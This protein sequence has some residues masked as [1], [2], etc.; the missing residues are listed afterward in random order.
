MKISD[1]AN[2]D[3]G[4]QTIERYCNLGDGGITSNTVLF[5]QVIGLVNQGVKN[6]F[7][8]LLTVD[9]QWKIDDSAYTDFPT[10]QIDLVSGTRDYLLP[11]A[12]VGGDFSTLYKINFVRV[13]NASGQKMDLLPL[14]PKDDINNEYYSAGT[15]TGTP[16]HYKLSGKSIILWPTPVTGSVTLT[17]GLEVDFQRSPDPFTTADTS[18]QFGFVDAFHDIPCLYASYHLLLPTNPS[19]A[20]TYFNLYTQRMEQL[21]DFYDDMDDAPRQQIIPKYRSSR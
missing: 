8:E 4:I 1:T 6:V 19:L 21:K 16:T 15:A 2:K 20:Q 9:K 7:A 18:Q 10:A 13:L 17:D 3:G 14:P 12:T 11:T 5:S